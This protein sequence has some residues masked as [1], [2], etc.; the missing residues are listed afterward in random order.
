VGGKYIL[1]GGL[2]LFAIGTAWIAVVG[3]TAVGWGRFMAPLAVMGVG[4][5][6]IFAPMATEAMRGVPPRLAGAASG[7]NTTIR[8]VGSVIGSAAVGAL[9][10]HQLA[11]SLREEAVARSG[12]VPV[13]YREPFVTGFEQAATGGLEVGAGQ[14][15]AAQHLP[16]GAPEAV[17]AQLQ[18]L[19]A[20]VFHHGFVAAMRPTLLLPVVVI[21]A[22]ALACLG[23]RRYRPPTPE[24]PQTPESP[25]AATA[26]A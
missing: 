8:Q 25:T 15:G 26:A 19:S 10:Q 2:S 18:R 6:C 14:T 23:M 11:S 3:D 12:Q 4:M 1:V 16:S 21:T 7:V 20:D 17:V 9:L 22:G 13:P 5:G 24:T